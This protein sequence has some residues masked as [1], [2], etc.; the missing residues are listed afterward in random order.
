MQLL[1]PIKGAPS[2][3]QKFGNKFKLYSDWHHGVDFRTWQYKN[4]ED[5]TVLA[6]HEG[7]VISVDTKSVGNTYYGNGGYQG[8]HYGIHCIIRFVSDGEIFYALYAHMSACFVNPGQKVS[9]GGKVG[10]SGNSGL[11]TR[12]H[13]HFELRKGE[14]RR[15]KAINPMKF[16]V[17]KV[18]DDVPAWGKESWEWAGQHKISS[19]H[20]V[21]EEDGRL[22]V[23]LKRL[24]ERFKLWFIPREELEKKFDAMQKEIDALKK[25]HSNK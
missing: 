22:M 9:L 11:S 24:S 15:S 5:K 8:S 18:E 21:F 2:I 25:A 17:D 12:D 19:E 14:N 7:E 16:F 1:W 20:S 4:H 23:F 10:T 6:A 3:S 13:L